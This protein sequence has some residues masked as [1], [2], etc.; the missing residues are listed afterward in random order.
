MDS[1][2]SGTKI[3]CPSLCITPA[4]LLNEQDYI[5]KIRG[6]PRP[7]AL[8][9]NANIYFFTQILAVA[10]LLLTLWL[11][12]LPALLGGLFVYFIVEFGA[13]HLSRVGVIPATGKIILLAIVAL[14]LIAALAAG[15]I[16]SISFITEGP[17]SLV[18]LLHR[19]ADVVQAARDYLPLWTHKYLPAN[20]EEWQQ[21]VSNW[22]LENAGHFSVYGKEVGL[23]LLHIIVGMIIGGMIAIS[24]AFQ[25]INGPLAKGLSDRV[26]FLS[27]AFRRIVFSQIRI[28]ALNTFLTA[29]FLAIVLPLTGN[30]L[31][32]TKAMIALTFIVGL[33]P[34]IGNLISNT[35]IFLIALSVSPV[36]AVGSLVFLIVI[37]KLEYFFN[38]HIIGTQIKARAWEILLA[39]VVME[40]MFGLA[41]LVAAPIYYAYL[42]DELSAQKLI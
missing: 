8:T 13:R 34:I 15:I 38:A 27:S 33:L 7:S 39:M 30:P 19:M 23:L 42:K 20:I 9:S 24:P 28:S 25:K 37:H 3:F 1:E 26:D 41:G 2:A 40:S 31:P 29:I 36:A 4:S 21:A 12:L 35:V 5:G 14:I 32:L 10:A 17:E 18:V 11:G 16:A 6:Q 22:L